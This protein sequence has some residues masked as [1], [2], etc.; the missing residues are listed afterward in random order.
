MRLLELS[1][2]ALGVAVLACIGRGVLA[3]LPPGD[4]GSHRPAA[5]PVT[6]A[7]SYLLACVF[8]ALGA[9]MAALLDVPVSCGWIAAAGALLALARW[10]TLP[11]ALVP[12]H[13]VRH[14]RPR[15]AARLLLAL[16]LGV[17]IARCATA[18]VDAGAG[19]WA[20]RAQAWL[21][22]GWLIGFDGPR[23]LRG[24]LDHAPLDAGALACLS[25]PSGVVGSLPARTHLLV[26]FLAALV[27]TEHV[28]ALARVAPLGRRAV[29]LLL[30]LALAPAVSV[31][32]GDL[33]LA[34]LCALAVGGSVAWARRADRR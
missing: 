25:W 2:A 29:V 8:F 12:R 17:A 19:L 11:A 31:E 10:A 22:Q 18:D 3:W 6:W 20:V 27:L 32:D 28:L 33:S 23:T 24:A 5:L 9:C 21:S 34:A 30:A 4:I 15:A 16:A 13:E 7:T 26:G 1:S 14:E